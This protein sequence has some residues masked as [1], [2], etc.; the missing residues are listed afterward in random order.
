MGSCLFVLLAFVLNEI[1]NLWRTFLDGSWTVWVRFPF[2][3]LGEENP[4]DHWPFATHPALSEA[5]RILL[6]LNESEIQLICSWFVSVLPEQRSIEQ[7]D[8]VWCV[9]SVRFFV[10]HML[11]RKNN[12][13]I[14]I[15]SRQISSYLLCLLMF[16]L[17][18]LL[19]EYIS[20]VGLL[21]N[22]RS[23]EH[24]ALISLAPFILLS[25]LF[26]LFLSINL[27][28]YLLLLL[29]L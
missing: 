19:S 4:R 26:L 5:R 15:S 13:Y 2:T 17:C 16:L 20:L 14:Q 28:I 3:Q 29:P 11:S 23:I 6:L 9:V 18:I 21:S 8:E 22:L 24:F 1:L 27:S 12:N 25:Y 7:R 10:E